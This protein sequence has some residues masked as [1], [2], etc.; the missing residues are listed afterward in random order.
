[1]SRAEYDAMV[2]AGR[3]QPDLYGKDLKHATSPP[4]PDGY[5]ASDAGSVFVEFDVS[6]SQVAKGGRNDWII[7]YGPNSPR[8]ILAARHNRLL[9]G[10][11]T[12][13]NIALI[14]LPET[15]NEQ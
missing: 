7:I 2:S 9:D 12:A 13:E 11:P 3:V 1:M 5:R 8:G 6:D 14:S 10:M 4:N 15:N